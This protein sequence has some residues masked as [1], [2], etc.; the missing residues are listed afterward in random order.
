M[1]PKIIHFCWLGGDAYPAKIRYCMDSWKRVLPD[2]EFMLWDTKRFDCSSVAWVQE[3]CDA[4]KYAFAADYIRCYALYHFGGIYLDSDVEVLRS[5]NDL[6]AL[7][8]F[9]GAERATGYIEAATMGFEKGHL[10]FRYLM[11]YYEGQHFMQNGKMNIK[12]MPRVMQEVLDA[13]FEVRPIAGIEAFD[14]NPQVINVCP[15]DYFSPKEDE[16]LFVTPNT[17]SIHHYTGTWR[18]PLYNRLRKVVIKCL[19]VKG[20]QKVAQL[21]HWCCRNKQ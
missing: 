2:Y 12:T 1:I 6:L 13:H 20:K 5:Y 19:G 11:D 3:A 9:V 14:P 18:S 8:Y 4:K 16:Q 15:K 17:Y 7:P 10:L 21:L